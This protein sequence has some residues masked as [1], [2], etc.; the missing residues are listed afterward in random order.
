MARVKDKVIPEGSLIHAEKI[1]VN[2]QESID[3]VKEVAE[4]LGID[5]N[6]LMMIM[7]VESGG[8]FDP[9]IKSKNSS[10]TG[11]I[12]F[13]ASTAEDLGTT[14]DKLSKMSFTEQM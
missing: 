9:S 12:Q 4:N 5:P 7:N 8:T 2:R 3:K 6:W 11:L 10:A 14:T 1:K 13:M